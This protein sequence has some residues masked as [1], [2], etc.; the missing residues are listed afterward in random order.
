M[1]Y[2][3][4][5]FTL[6]LFLF[7]IGHTQ[8]IGQDGER[9]RS[10]TYD[11]LSLEQVITSLE[12]LY[13]V[14]IYYKASAELGRQ[15]SIVFEDQTVEQV[16]EDLL[17]SSTLSYISYR[18]YAYVI[19]PRSVID[20]SYS[21]DF[22]AALESSITDE[23]E[24]EERLVIGDIESLDP[25]GLASIRG[26][27]VDAQTGEAVIGAT[28][29]I[30]ELSNG[31]TSDIDGSYQLDNVAAG[32]HEITIGYIGYTDLY[33][34]I[35]L[36]STGNFDVNLNKSDIQLSEVTIRA[37]AADASVN[38]VQIGVA[39]MDIKEIK[40]LPTFLGEV[41]V[42]KSFLLQPGVST[43]GEGASGFNV[44]GG[45]VDQNLILQDETILFNSSHALGFFSTFNS[46]LIRKVD[47]YKANVPAQ[48]GGRLVSVLDVEMRDGDF[49]RFR[50]K[51]GI[52]PISSKIAAEG[53][54]I[55]DKVAF[56]GGFRSSY[57][58]WLL[59]QISNVEVQRSS[60]FFY[61]GNLRITAK[62]SDN[63]TF[64]FSGY[65]TEDDFSFN[66]EFG[67]D[68][69]TRSGE[70]TYRALLSDKMINTFSAVASSYESSQLDL[71]GFDGAQID[72]NVAYIKL[73]NNFKVVPQEGIELNLGVSTIQYTVDPGIR[74]P[75]GETSVIRPITIEE[76]KGRESAVYA[77]ISYALSDALQVTGGARFSLYQ[78]LGPHDEFQYEDPL[79]PTNQ[80]IGEVI[81]KTGTVASFSNIEPRVSL[82]YSLG[83]SSSVKAGYSRTAQYIN[84]IF[85][86]DSP[87]PSSQWQLSTRYITP[88]TSQNVSIGYFKNFSDNTWE[89]SLEFY[90][91]QIDDL[92]DYIDFA[93]LLINDHLET[94]LLVGEGRAFGA[95]LSVKKNV[96][97]LTGWLA[98]TY[99][100]S[101]RR[102]DGINDGEWYLSNFDKTHDASLILNYNPN[103][104]N[105][106]SMN[107]TY[108]TGRPTTPPL[109]NIITPDNIIIPLFSDRN[110]SRIPDFFRVDLSYTIGQS[111]KKEK[112]F[113]TSWTFSVF[114]VLGRRNPF[115]VFFTRAPFER[116]QANRLAIIGAAF[117]SL[118]VNIELQ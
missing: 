28:V 27:V 101:E 34:I 64:I 25:S 38:Q 86:T 50:L 110:S 19:A 55:K 95:E 13:D 100:R 33:Q 58:D 5:R 85:N 75:V 10:S 47:L 57:T 30:E 68:Y 99:S 70:L 82:R 109:G 14:D 41:D 66:E 12:T 62:P 26:V 71:D 104:R 54:I 1:R 63:H 98:Y 80:N 105:T 24:D 103:Q 107:V 91:R 39:T 2:T 56:V 65:I 72:N 83:N 114:N 111:Y 52:G 31:T 88:P 43:V 36:R 61:D 97:A 89:T 8:A 48:F 102:V 92:F 113:R 11:N 46:D 44:R 9:L 16:L 84:Q 23:G 108:S 37:R 106:F 78:F 118:T 22:Y 112:A 40:K 74:T 32:R 67:F 81:R 96:G 73:K 59:G 117:P 7:A 3:L 51:A 69:G 4:I 94:D 53:P 76:E 90:G 77:D 115:T 93:T 29:Q 21:S 17:G 87:T 35:D 60:S 20:R 45:N 49:E 18:D 15:V 42:I 116:V 79:N 6:C